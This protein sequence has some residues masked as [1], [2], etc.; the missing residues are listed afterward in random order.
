VE[1]DHNSPNQLV[2][3]LIG[4]DGTTVLLQNR[5]GADQH[6]INAIYGKTD[7]SAQTLGLFQG[8]Q[9][10][11]VWTL[12]VED[13]VLGAPGTIRNFAVTL[14]PGQPIE[15]IPAAAAA[16]ARVLPVVAHI[17]GTKFFKSDVRIYNPG[18]GPSLLSLYYVAAGQTGTTAA[19]AV[20]TI[21]AGQV[22]ALND[23]VQ[24][25][26]NLDDS[27]GQL[28]VL[29]SPDTGFLATSRAYT[30]GDN[31]T[32][33][34]FIPGFK[35]PTGIA[36]GGGSATANGLLKSSQFHTNLGFTEVSGAPVTV[37]MDIYDGNGLFLASTSRSTD[38]YTTLLV[39]DIISDRSL[40]ATSN[41]RV[42]YT[43][44]SASGRVV[45]FATYLDDVTGDGSF[46]S[47]VTP[48]SSAQDV[49]VAQT[50]HVTGANGDFFQTNLNVTNL[51]TQPVTITVSLLPLQ[52]TGTPNSP[53]VYTLA[54]GQTLEKL[55]VLA[56]EFGL[57]DPSSAGL[58]IHPAGPA[59]LA[60][61]TR[62]FVPKFGGTFGF[63]V[64]GLP[65]SRAI[66]LGTTA[67][68]IQL[69]QT[70]DVN[71]YRSNFGFTEVAGSP[72]TVRVT[73]KSGDTAAVLGTKD[74]PIGANSSFQANVTDILGSGA[75]AS[76]L[77]LQFA[78]VSGSGRVIP[79]GA[80]VDNKSGDAILMPAE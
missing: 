18:A 65:A 36:F 70:T 14:L 42:N 7:A 54:P 78:V 56:S 53:R 73:A 47:A 37:R 75:V 23:V 68:V 63:S 60:V 61:S 33:G 17:Q 44:T 80:S 12:R 48:Q 55:D 19:K 67:T 15:A 40:P 57:A 22:L 31:G 77:Y 20:Q 59:R 32:F 64:P 28:T 10:N 27:I 66:G 43:V 69:D 2:V 29:A 3:T 25:Q 62:T 26:Y 71:G 58:R 4:P 30:Q 6:P 34:L 74:Y 46:Q 45:P 21:P 79:Y 16:G 50:A 52:I 1:I 72:A 38:P 49:I 13:K 9:A 51:D 41:F 8:K 11:G 5:T 39:Q 24:S 35:N 76:N